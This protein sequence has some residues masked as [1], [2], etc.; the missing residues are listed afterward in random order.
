MMKTNSCIFIFIVILLTF[1]ACSDSSKKTNKSGGSTETENKETN[2]EAKTPSTQEK[3]KKEDAG[4]FTDKRDGKKYKTVKI[5]DRIWLAQ[6][7]AYKAKKDEATF[8]K[9]WPDGQTGKFWVYDDNEKNVAKYGYLY[10]YEAAKKLAPKG[11]R[12]PTKGEF[13]SLINHFGKDYKAITKNKKGLGVVFGGWYYEESGYVRENTEVGFWTA[14]KEDEEN[15]W[16]CIV[17]GEWKR[18]GMASRFAIGT[19]AAVRYIK[20]NT[21]SDSETEESEKTTENKPV[22]DEFKDSS[23]KTDKGD[24]DA[25]IK[26]Y[27]EIIKG[28]GY[29]VENPDVKRNFTDVMV[30]KKNDKV[31]M[32]QITES[33]RHYENMWQYFYKDDKLI[34]TY[35]KLSNSD[36]TDKNGVTIY[37]REERKFYFSDNKCILALFSNTEKNKEYAEY[38]SK[39]N[40]VLKEGIEYLEISKTNKWNEF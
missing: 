33:D 40:E 10:D 16:L 7:F 21:I 30:K 11:W 12:L 1:S 14:T 3:Q 32:I 8:S 18:V 38:K 24:F 6:N 34:Y 25:I 36:G 31:K 20:D 2:K 13:E 28:D 23:P 29:V 35:I 27:D 26:L 5:G 15:V 4:V 19:G 37:N 17:E 9:H 22:Y 39:G